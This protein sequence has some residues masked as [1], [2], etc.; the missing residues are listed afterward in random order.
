MKN[1]ETEMSLQQFIDHYY[2]GDDQAALK[3]TGNSIRLRI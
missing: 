2:P 1:I 3:K